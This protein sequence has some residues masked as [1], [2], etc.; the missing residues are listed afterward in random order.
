MIYLSATSNAAGFPTLS[1]RIFLG[2]LL[3]AASACRPSSESS[4]PQPNPQTATASPSDAD[5]LRVNAQQRDAMQGDQPVESAESSKGSASPAPLN[6]DLQADKSDTEAASVSTLIHLTDVTDQSGITF[7]HTT[8]GNGKGYV[9][10]GMAGGLAVFDYDNDGLEDIYLLNGAPLKGTDPPKVVP[11]NAMYRNLGSMRFEDTTETTALGDSGYGLGVVAGDYDS[12]GDLDLYLSNF[13]PNVLLRNDNGVFVNVTETA[14]V[15]NG[16][17]VGAGVSFF[18]YDSDGDIDLYASNYVDFNYDNFVPIS[19]KGVAFQAGPQYYPHIPDTLYRNNAD[20]T[21]TDVSEE[22]GVAKYPG[23]GMS[24]LGWDVDEDGDMDMFVCNDGKPNFLLVND[25]KGH[26]QDSAMLAGLAYDFRGK[27]N[28]SMGV[29]SGDVDGDGLIDLFVTDYQ[30]EMPVLYRGVKPMLFED[31]TSQARIDRELFAHVHWGTALADLDNDGDKD[32]FIACGHF[33]PIELIDDHTSQKVRNYVLMNLG[34]GTFTNVSSI[35][36]DGMQ[37][38]L[39]SRGAATS[40]LDNDG[41]LDI[42]ILN[43]NAKPTLLRND[44][45]SNGKPLNHW[46]GI[47]LRSPGPNTYAVGAKVQVKTARGTQVAI[48][49]SSRGYQ[50]YFGTRLHFG[51]GEETNVESVTVNWPM[52]GAET[53]KITQ[54]DTQV[55]LVQGQGIALQQSR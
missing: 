4:I 13:G 14:G 1:A 37:V 20:G 5:A 19:I 29:D 33:D 46:L 6:T 38:T 3:M 17:R 34:D 12:D 10:E 11:R 39:S 31:A 8:G 32:L 7:E 43:S 30:A 25:G 45:E 54:I 23:P 21:F 49:Q 22:S 42:I 2:V 50:S 28:S 40:D 52:D 16:D 53:F 24:T 26:F 18:D 47:K 15:A 41:D 35:A 9:V 36:G 44:L 55:E 51:L 48:Q 27:A